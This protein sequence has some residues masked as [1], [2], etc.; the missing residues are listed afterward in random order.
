MPLPPI[1]PIGIGTA[2]ARP[3]QAWTATLN[4]WLVD[5]G[6]TNAPVIF[7]PPSPL[8]GGINEA[9]IAASGGPDWGGCQIWASLDGNTYRLVGTVYRG[10]ITGSSTASFPAH[11]SPDTGDT[12]SVDVSES[13]GQILSGTAADANNLI[14]LCWI[15]GELIAYQTATLTAPH[16]YDLGTLI[17]RGAYGTPITAHAS[18]G[19]FARINGSVFQYAFPG[20]LVPQT[21]YVKLP[22]FNIFGQTLQDLSV[23]TAYT[24]TTTGAG[25]NPLDMPVLA[26]LAGGTTQ[27][28]GIAGTTVIAT[29]DLAPIGIANGLGITLGTLS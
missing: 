6:D 12:L 27:D 14:T 8:T 26:T 18:G 2:A 22:A 4:N 28:W 7:E 16:R 1:Q 13:R 20:N 29:A 3:H 25:T 9:W 15:D 19:R 10:C 21:F 23:V 17:V 5:P 24:Y 11:T